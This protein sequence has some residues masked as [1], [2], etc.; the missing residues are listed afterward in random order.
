MLRIDDEDI[1]YEEIAYAGDGTATLKNC[2]RGY[3]GTSPATHAKAVSVQVLSPC[4]SQNTCRSTATIYILHDDKLLQFMT[5]CGISEYTVRLQ[6]T[7]GQLLTFSFQGRRMG[8]AGVSEVAAAPVSAEVQLK[9]GGT[10]AYTVGAYVRNKTRNDDNNGAGYR[11]LAVNGRTGIIRLS[12]APSGWQEGDQLHPWMPAARPV[13]TVLESR[14]ANVV[15]NGVTG[16]MNDGTLTYQ[17]P[18][19]NLNEIGDEFPG[20]GIDGKRTI[21]LSRSINF[22]AKDG[23]EFGRGYRGYE[24][25]VAVLAGKQPGLTLSHVMPRVRF[26]TPELGESDNALT[27]TQDGGALGV[28]GEDAFFIIQE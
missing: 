7:Q 6:Q 26:N 23:A 22:R 2:S 10:D 19:T 28:A 11:V 1:R 13:G 4:Y 9:N 15:V 16:K 21:S 17:S 24:L 5:G 25:P 20:E 18:L 27:L 3:G 8:W 12:A 14:H